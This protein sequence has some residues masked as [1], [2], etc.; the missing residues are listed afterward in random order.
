MNIVVPIDFSNHSK[1]AAFYAAE[2]V[3]AQGGTL[4]L[5]HVLVPME[6]E[7][8]Y[9]PVET[10]QA[11]RNTVFEMFSLQQAIRRKTEVRS[12]CDLLPGEIAPQII[13]AARGVKA[14]LIV[15]GTQGNSGLRKHLYGSHTAEVLQLSPGPVLT[16]PEGAAF[17]NIERIV[18]ATDYSYSNIQDIRE[19]ASFARNFNAVISLVHVNKKRSAAWMLDDIRADFEELIRA[20]VDYPYIAFEEFDNT[21]TAEGLRLLLQNGDADLLIIPNR[22]RSLVERITGRG[23]D[24]DFLFDLDVPLLVV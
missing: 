10:I 12:S 8:D 19:I 11:K 23:S 1:D 9:M 13:R 20:E 7:P 3:K 5:V 24:D 15:M 2:L 16:L 21:D 6:D 22:R 14:D 4:H 17:K 18:Y